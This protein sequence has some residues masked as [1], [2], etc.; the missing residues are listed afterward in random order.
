MFGEYDSNIKYLSKRLGISVVRDTNGLK[1]IG[2]ETNRNK[3]EEIIAA[4]LDKVEKGETHC[5]NWNMVRKLTK[6]EN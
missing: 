5:R 4:L 1:V 3:L 6:K 2:E